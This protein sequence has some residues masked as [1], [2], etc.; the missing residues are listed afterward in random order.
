MD[1]ELL[2]YIGA[3]FLGG[4]ILNVMP[5][6]LPVLTMKV[7]N[8]I[9]H[10]AEAPR[11]NRIHG[12]AYSAGV[13]A[14]FLLFAIVII[15]LRAS[16]DTFGWGMQFQSP[17]FVAGMTALIFAFGLNAL[18][19]FEFS[20]SMSGGGANEGYTGSFVNGIVASIMSTPCSAPFLG[21]AAAFALG[22]GAQWWQTLLMFS[23]IGLGL[24]SPFAL[25]SF[26]PAIGRALPR[27]GAWMETFKMMMGF[28][29]IAAAIW[30][31]GVL[32]AQVTRTSSTL[33]LF[34]LLLLGIALWSLDHFGGLQHGFGRRLGVRLGAAG[35]VIDGAIGGLVDMTPPERPAAGFTVAGADAPAVL[36]DH[37]NWAPFDADRVAKERDR[38]RPVFM[39]FTADW[40][41]N[42][43]ANERVF[44]ETDRIRSVLVETGVLS[45]KA[46]MTN[47]NDEIDLWLSKLGRS[48][49]PAYVIYMPDGS[50][51]LLPE[52][53][54]TEMLAERLIA[55]A[56]RFPPSGHGKGKA[57]TAMV[58]P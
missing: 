37:I 55:A 8:V 32:Q 34:F 54:T 49:I 26:V 48:G 35:V 4:V 41:A 20:V 40:C 31:F 24:A 28:S 33:F 46:D 30:L 25:I 53:I 22:S 51:D 38:S 2:T 7:F 29:L 23:F 6:V 15:G 52:A 42:C 12:L 39:D 5:C 1:M 18:G 36:N 56:K 14:T 9:E 10:S 57:T 27:P 11:E 58:S 21:S 17:A 3:A 13:L 47:E 19:V 50:Y 43:K 44:I 16:G 45:M